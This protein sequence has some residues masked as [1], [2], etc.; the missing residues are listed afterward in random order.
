[1]NA[2]STRLPSGGHIEDEASR[3]APFSSDDLEGHEESTEFAPLVSND[4]DGDEG[5]IGPQN[6]GKGGGDRVANGSALF[7]IR[8]SP[9]IYRM[10]IFAA[11]FGFLFGAL[12]GTLVAGKQPTGRPNAPEAYSEDPLNLIDLGDSATNAPSASI[13]EASPGTE[14]DATHGSPTNSPSQ[15][16]VSEQTVKPIVEDLQSEKDI[17]QPSVDSKAIPVHDSKPLVAVMYNDSKAFY[18]AV[19][20]ASEN[21]EVINTQTTSTG[22]CKE[23]RANK[24]YSQKT[25]LFNMTYPNCRKKYGEMG[26]TG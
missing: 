17:A 15:A 9:Q 14:P 12:F 6:A 21:M 11:L 1:M 24:Q 2:Q 25:F 7:G 26:G 8:P 4:H 18:T 16:A 22:I 5:S 23:I 13:S 19:A 10:L 20:K 3:E